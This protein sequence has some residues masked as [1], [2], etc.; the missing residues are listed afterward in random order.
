MAEIPV[1][2]EKM[3]VIA[4]Q[5]NFRPAGKVLTEAFSIPEST[6][7][8]YKICTKQDHSNVVFRVDP[9]QLK[10]G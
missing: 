7:Q 6:E 10:T 9:D 2:E 1:D 8:V 3:H 5:M 4:Y